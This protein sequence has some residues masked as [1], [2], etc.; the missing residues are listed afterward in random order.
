MTVG[1]MAG[2]VRSLPPEECFRLAAGCSEHADVG[3]VPV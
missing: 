3:C 2:V 1:L